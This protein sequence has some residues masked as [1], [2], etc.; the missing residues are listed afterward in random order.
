VKQGIPNI[1]R[2]KEKLGWFPVVGIDE[3]L[4]RTIDAMRGTETVTLE[5]IMHPEK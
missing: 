5:S 1:H 2:A 4:K 3:G